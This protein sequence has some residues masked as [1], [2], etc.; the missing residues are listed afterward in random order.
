[1]RPTR[2][3]IKER[4][5]GDKSVE[6]AMPAKILVVEDNPDSREM[7]ACLLRLKGYDIVSATDG[8]EAF[9]LLER[10][11]PDL[12][13]TDIQMPNVDGIEMIRRLRKH[14]ELN[15]V[16]ILVMSAYRSGVVSE[17]MAA[18][19]N[20]STRKPVEWHSLHEIIRQLLPLYLLVAP[21]LQGCQSLLVAGG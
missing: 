20:A 19:A 13:I 16:P 15:Q 1:M 14:S 17:A 9:D 6:S 5:A 10:E 2:N 12:I 3:L 8:Q 11:R 7:I 18:G 4:P 21:L